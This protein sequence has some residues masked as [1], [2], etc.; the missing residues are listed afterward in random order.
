[1]CLAQCQGP[2]H[3]KQRGAHALLRPGFFAQRFERSHCAHKATLWEPLLRSRCAVFMLV[4]VAGVVL[5][6]RCAFH[7]DGE[8]AQP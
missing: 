2:S 7:L 4:R 8:L 6:W 5:R 1:M 3:D